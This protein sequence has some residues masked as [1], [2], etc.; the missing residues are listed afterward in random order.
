MTDYTKQANDFLNETGTTF[1]A[2]LTG[3][4][5][6]FP[7]DKDTRDIY[8]ITL[9]RNKKTYSFS[10]GQSINNSGNLRVGNFKRKCPTAYDVLSCL[11][12]YDVGTFEDFCAD[13]GYSSD[14]SQAEKTY[15]N[16]QKEYSEVY[17]LFSDVM[18]KLQEIN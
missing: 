3:H 18:D 11:T 6:Y 10:F 12:K 15:F 14:S 4:G 8:E 17:R 1:K 16:V 5:K 7:D 13:Y 2:V 9:T